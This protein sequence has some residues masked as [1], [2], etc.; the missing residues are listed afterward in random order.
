MFEHLFEG[1]HLLIMSKVEGHFLEVWDLP[2]L[3]EGAVACRACKFCHEAF[4][5][6]EGLAIHVGTKLVFDI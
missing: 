6:R 4:Q 2:F 1:Y 3:H 5:L